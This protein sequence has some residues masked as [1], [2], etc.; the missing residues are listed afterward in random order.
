[1][2]LHIQRG[3]TVRFLSSYAYN[4]ATQLGFYLPTHYLIRNEA[5]VRKDPCFGTSG[6]TIVP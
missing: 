6:L 2:I 4:V 5:L 1:M 3:D